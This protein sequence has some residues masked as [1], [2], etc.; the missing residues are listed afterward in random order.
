VIQYCP[1]SSSSLRKKK[2]L[3]VFI[4]QQQDQLHKCGTIEVHSFINLIWISD[5]SCNHTRITKV[6]LDCLLYQ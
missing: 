3:H 6:G 4:W 5:I 1:G 2:D